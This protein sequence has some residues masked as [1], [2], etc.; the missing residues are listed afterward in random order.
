MQKNKDEEVNKKKAEEAKPHPYDV[1]YGLL[2]CSLEHVDPKSDE[3]KTI[4]KYTQ[5]TQGYRKCTIIDVWRVGR[6]EEVSL[7]EWF[8]FPHI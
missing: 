2:K 4:H 6:E 8:F 3:F 1:N 7:N 5:N